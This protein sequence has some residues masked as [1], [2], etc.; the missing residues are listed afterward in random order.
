VKADKQL[1]EKKIE[2]IN[3]LEKNRMATVLLLN[4]MTLRVPP[5]TVWLTG[6]KDAGTNLQLDGFAMDNL[7]VAQFM[8]NLEQSPYITS[9]DL[10]G[11]GQEIVSNTKV[12]KFSIRCN[13]KRG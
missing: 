3:N 2:I 13:L 8:K 6:F 10:N 12:Q 1:L 7:A 11:S 4:E 5:G 9:V